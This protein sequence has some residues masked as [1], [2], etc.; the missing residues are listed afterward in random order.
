MKK[1]ASLEKNIAK[2]PFLLAYSNMLY[3]YP[4]AVFP[5][6]VFDSFEIKSNRLT[7][8]F[9]LSVLLSRL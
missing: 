4:Y 1:F 6:L 8:W 9:D 2:F 5:F 7:R 3:T